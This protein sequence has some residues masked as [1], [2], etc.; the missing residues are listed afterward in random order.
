M[1]KI[2]NITLLIAIITGIISVMVLT[3][4]YHK[5]SKLIQ[6]KYNKRK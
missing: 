1:E 5:Q 6:Q 2:T 3:I 4:D